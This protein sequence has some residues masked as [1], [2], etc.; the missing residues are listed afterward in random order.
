M[1]I[2][3]KKLIIDN[4]LSIGHGEVTLDNKGYTLI[5]GINHNAKDNATSNGSG[6]CFGKGTKVLMSD[7]SS[8]NIEDIEVGDLVM[9]WDSTPR[10]VLET[11]SGKGQLYKVSGFNKNR[12]DYSYVCNDKHL[13]CL[14]H[15]CGNKKI[16]P[17]L[18]VSISEFNELPPY[19][20]RQ[21]NQYIVPVKKFYRKQKDLKLN[22]YW[23]GVWL[24][25]GTSE[26]PDI[27][28]M[29]KEIV[30]TCYEIADY[31]HL[32]VH[33]YT[34]PNNKA[35]TYSM[36]TTKGQT[37][38]FSKILK[39]LNVW[40]NKHIPDEYL[41]SSYENR[42]KLL[43][44][45]LD[46]DG[47]KEKQYVIS[48][49]Q[50][51]K[52]LSEQIVFLARSLGFKTT[53]RPKEVKGKVYY[54]ISI[55]GETWKIPLR[56]KHKIVEDHYSQRPYTIG[57]YFEELGIGDYYGFQIE[58]DGKFLL[59]NCLVVH[60]S[61]VF[62]ALCFALTGETISGIS[63]N[64]KNI[65]TTGEMK[66]EL[67][68]SIDKDNY[69]IIRSRDDKN[70]PNLKFFINSED[71]SGKTLRESEE[72][73]NKYIPG[74]TG[75]LLG[76]VILL[77]QG[78][79]HRFSNNT[80]SGRKEILERLSNND[81]MLYDIK[82]RVENRTSTLTEKKTNLTIAKTTLET[83]KSLYTKQKEE[84]ERKLEELKKSSTRDFNKEIEECQNKI[85][86]L[87]L[88]QSKLKSEIDEK[89]ENYFKDNQV[90]INIIGEKNKK[91]SE[92]ESIFKQYNDIVVKELN[93][94]KA[95]LIS[96]NK[97]INRLSSITD[98][99]PTCHQKIQGVHKPDLT[100][101][102]K[103]QENLNNLIKELTEKDSKQKEAYRLNCKDIEDETKK[104]LD[105]LQESLNKQKKE[106]SVI[107]NNYNNVSNEI[108]KQQNTLNTLKRDR[109]ILDSKIEET[110]KSIENAKIELDNINSQLLYNIKDIDNIQSHLDVVSKM[111]TYVKRDF[112]GILLSN[113]IN[114]INTKSKEYALDIFGN[115]EI[116]FILNGNNIDIKY[117]NKPLELLSGGEQQK[118][119]LIVQF[120]I[121]SMMQEYTGFNS[122]IIILDEILDNLD[123]RG[124]DQ[125]I[126]FITN[127]LSDIE[128]VFIISHHADSLNIS[129]DS[130]IIIIK[131]S[132]GVSSVVEK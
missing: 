117:L 28:T 118:V 48:I 18:N 10:K 73:L 129:N 36:T 6:K 17:E 39:E 121:R 46:T 130:R 119:N 93:E 74:L 45:L 88:D 131:D 92:E 82:E 14:K 33:I 124:C 96:L 95:N 24:G 2:K 52:L 47:G 11:H 89:E 19:L 85:K 56:V 69:V 3:F 75:E 105:N 5:E 44:G 20:Q 30:E 123:A 106:I 71:K 116:E 16:N 51:R 13:L 1:K 7:G 90:N 113:V 100:E 94:A 49:S 80:P 128:S 126:N 25:D 22:P 31:Y 57:T 62:N 125:V 91:L 102:Y 53:I 132:K 55:L 26:K 86:E 50:E 15:T 87:E 112:R 120:A 110:T 34:K 103:E 66:V 64:L 40:G 77:G 114:Y 65:L 43:C 79:P 107:K 4:F 23:L 61:S 21:Y 97:E 109:D 29:D 84:N 67:S 8:K 37:N 9:G 111:L 104:E 60:N 68:F 35:S 58:G 41:Y 81:I 83:K 42:M 99:C 122:N 76:E 78:L 12:D 59:D 32:N 72:Q 70:K 101:Q 38:G 115:D 27:T 108:N 54:R 127:K 98:I 63:S